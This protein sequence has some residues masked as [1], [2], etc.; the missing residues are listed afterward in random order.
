MTPQDVQA[1]NSMVA[2][3]LLIDSEH[4]RVPF[5]PGAT[6]SSASPY[7][8]S[9]LSRESERLDTPLSVM[10]P[11]GR[12]IVADRVI[13][14]CTVQVG[15]SEYPV[16]LILLDMLEF[17]IILGMDWLSSCYATVDCRQ[18]SVMFRHLARPVHVYHGSRGE[19]PYNLISVLQA[20]RLLRRGCG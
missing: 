15:E 17:D 3:I 2:G 20:H 19:I 9:Y 10:T 6:H 16:N 11:V 12:A 18:K 14:S 4:A 1:S 13:P 5:D 8:A 7:F